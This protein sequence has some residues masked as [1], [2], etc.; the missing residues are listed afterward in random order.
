MISPKIILALDYGKKRIGVAVSDPTGTLATPLPFLPAE[1]FE[2]LAKALESIVQERGVSLIL[3]GIP[4]NTDGSMGI[5][6]QAAE[7]FLLKLQ[8]RLS[9]EVKT[10]DERFST[11]QA[12]KLLHEAGYDTRKQKRKIDSAAAQIILQQFLDSNSTFY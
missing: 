12:K 6:A 7:K 9:I 8:K 4:R 11:V 1:S 5:S 10:V 3:V 2:E